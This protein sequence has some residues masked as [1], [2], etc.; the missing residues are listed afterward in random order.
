MPSWESPTGTMELEVPTT[1]S[2]TSQKHP[3]PPLARPSFLL[4]DSPDPART[5]GL[6]RGP[7]CSSS[8][9]CQGL[10]P[11]PR[12]V[13]LGRGGGHS[14][15]CLEPKWDWGQGPGKEAGG[16]TGG[17]KHTTCSCTHWPLDRQIS[18]LLSIL[19]PVPTCPPPLPPAQPL[20]SQTLNPYHSRTSHSPFRKCGQELFS[21]P[22][23]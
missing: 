1:T 13:K 7:Y 16:H 8:H 20:K 23:T 3:P 9:K 12:R 10:L 17:H 15:Q 2:F 18:F 14:A 11:A 5:G 22:T 6:Y 4:K 19:Y 21:Y